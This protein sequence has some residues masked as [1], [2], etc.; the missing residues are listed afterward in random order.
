MKKKNIFMAGI[1]ALALVFAFVLTG[2]PEEDP[3]AVSEAKSSG[4]AS[5]SVSLPGIDNPVV[6][7]RVLS[8]GVRLS[9][10]SV[11]E[12]DSYQVWRRFGNQNIRIY[13]KSVDNNLD[14]YTYTDTN[15]IPNTT[16]TYTV[17]AMPSTPV[18]DHGRWSASVTTYPPLFGDEGVFTVN[19]FSI[20]SNAIP[21]EG[22]TVT[23]FYAALQLSQIKATQ[24]VLYSVERATLDAK[25][26]PGT[27]STPTLS[28]YNTS[29]T[30]L[31]PQ[32]M[33][34]FGNLS[35]SLA[36]VFDR[37]LPPTEATYQYRLKGVRTSDNLTEYL[38]G[39]PGSDRVV[40]DFKPYLTSRISLNIGSKGGEASAVYTITP[41]LSNGTKRN[42]LKEG[43]KV[44]LYW[45]VGKSD[46]YSTGPY[47]NTNIV[48][49]GKSD[50]ESALSTPTTK[51]LDVPQKGGDTNQY[52]Y[53]QAW[54]ERVNGDKLPLKEGSNWTGAGLQ[55]S[56]RNNNGQWHQQLTY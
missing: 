23:G 36:A 53:V 16:Y 8:N 10:Y 2:C 17:L 42:I 50:I 32:T 7:V 30:P 40:I 35:Y 9:W 5:G 28:L 25:G 14:S 27:W 11:M 13:T 3:E 1:L 43:D 29:D 46:C 15:T 41:G 47:N 12:A 44:V 20:N 38:Y 4:G 54:L 21:N 51:P 48:V 31:P 49:F 45:I 55:G 19:S 39:N 52:L 24:G 22:E 37:S 56:L 34:I 6:T 33:D 26:N 18:R